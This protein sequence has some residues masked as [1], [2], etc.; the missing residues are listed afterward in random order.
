MI[1]TPQ[2]AG[3]FAVEP[4]NHVR[5]A[6]NQP[7]PRALGLVTLQPGQS[8]QAWMTLEVQPTH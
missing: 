4:V 2:D 3:H 8:H 1:Y 6:I 5:N 7:A